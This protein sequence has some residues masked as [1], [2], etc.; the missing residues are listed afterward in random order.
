MILAGSGA[1]QPK[2]LLISP[3]SKWKKCYFLLIS[4]AEVLFTYVLNN[5]LLW[6]SKLFQNPELLLHW[7]MS[8]PIRSAFL[9]AMRCCFCFFYFFYD[10]AFRL[11]G[12]AESCNIMGIFVSHPSV[13]FECV[14]VLK[15]ATHMFFG[16]LL[17]KQQT[18]IYKYAP[19]LF[20]LNPHSPFWAIT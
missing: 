6:K 20:S 14:G 19:L 4:V 12:S 2:R 17:F 10:D 9:T 3:N 11:I 5:F 13:T 16:I 15:Q 7:S 8:W 18:Y 1:L